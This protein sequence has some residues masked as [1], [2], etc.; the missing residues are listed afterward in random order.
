ME[1]PKD[2]YRLLGVSRNASPAAIRRAYRRLAKQ[3]HP[4]S[5]AG[6]SL[7]AFQE[8]Q[9]A[10]ETLSDT[11]RRQRYDETLDRVGSSDAFAPLAWSFVRGPAAGDLRRPVQA[12][13]L[14]GEILLTAEEAQAGG[15][16]PLDIP[17]QG[18]CPACGGTGGSAFDC[19]RCGGE[20]AIQRRMPLPVRIPQGVRDGAVFQVNVDEPGVASV[21]LTVHIRRL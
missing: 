17:L 20:G 10:Y 6:S 13:S 4:E 19:G 14:S 21:L 1:K 2:F 7:E 12:G 11:E 16:L 18:S 15:I 5:G 3:Y 9:A 8:L